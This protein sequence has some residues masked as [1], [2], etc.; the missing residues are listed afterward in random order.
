[1]ATSCLESFSNYCVQHPHKVISGVICGT[2]L[3]GVAL[4]AADAFWAGGAWGLWPT[5]NVVATVALKWV[6]ALFASLGFLPIV[7]AATVLVA[8]VVLAWVYLICKKSTT[9]PQHT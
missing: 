5:I 2:A 1:M 8:G 4:V 9:P 3:L 6:G 7:L